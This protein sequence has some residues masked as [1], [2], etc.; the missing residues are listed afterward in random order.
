MSRN[1]FSPR[2]SRRHEDPHEGFDQKELRVSSCPSWLREITSGMNRYDGVKELFGAALFNSP[3]SRL[4]TSACRLAS[5]MLSLT[6]IVPHSAAPLLD[7]MSTLVLA[8]VP[9]A[10][11][12]M[13][14]L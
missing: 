13:R 4:S 9:V 8:A 1:S 12:M 11:S 2:V 10:E 14:T 6:P 5:I 3:Y 7:S